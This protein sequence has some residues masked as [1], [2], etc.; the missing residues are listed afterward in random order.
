[1]CKSLSHLSGQCCCL[2]A[3]CGFSA[4]LISFACALQDKATTNERGS[5]TDVSEI[6]E[7]S[8]I[9]QCYSVCNEL[10]SR[11]TSVHDRRAAM[12]MADSWM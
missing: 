7:P 8:I 2:S 4:P 12:V 3:A 10:S 5:P 6:K 1:M 11:L 9:L